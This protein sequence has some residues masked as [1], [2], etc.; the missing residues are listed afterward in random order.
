MSLA[1]SNLVDRQATWRGN[2]VGEEMK[3][4]VD[5]LSTKINLF[6]SSFTCLSIHQESI[7]PARPCVT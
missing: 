6:A 3:L 4:L 7:R 1:V 2:G 5:G